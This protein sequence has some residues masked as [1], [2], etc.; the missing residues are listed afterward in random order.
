MVQPIEHIFKTSSIFTH[1]IRCIYISTIQ[2][3]H[4][5]LVF[6]HTWTVL[7]ALKCDGR[8]MV[9]FICIHMLGLTSCSYG[10]TSEFFLFNQ[11]RTKYVH[12]HINIIHAHVLI[13]AWTEREKHFEDW[14]DN[15]IC[16]SSTFWD[17][18]GG[19]VNVTTLQSRRNNNLVVWT[20][21]MN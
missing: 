1:F 7:K 12:T 16:W 20:K 5:V 2:S 9:D 10:Y 15:M 4:R 21:Y 6:M 19:R 18:R 14:R 11:I 13:N 3:A 8:I 17:A